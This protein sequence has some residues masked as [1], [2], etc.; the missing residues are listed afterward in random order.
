MQINRKA[1]AW[2]FLTWLLLSAILLY[3]GLFASP[4][5]ASAAYAKVFFVPAIAYGCSIGIGFIYLCARIQSRS[6]GRSTVVMRLVGFGVVPLVVG[7]IGFESGANFLPGILNAFVGTTYGELYTVATVVHDSG[8]DRC[9]HIT[10]RELDADRS[11]RNL[12]VSQLAV[13]TLKPGDNV[14]FEGA[15]S[16]F[17]QSVS[18]YAHHQK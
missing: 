12:C 4:F 9:N 17:G 7:L 13:D 10:L 1:T 15:Q 16:W 8:S 6:M 18:N 2:L 5:F 3:W 14:R 11:F